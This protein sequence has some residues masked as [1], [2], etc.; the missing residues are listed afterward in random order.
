MTCKW[1]DDSQSLIMGYFDEIQNSPSEIYY[2]ALSFCPPSSWLCEHYSS[3]LPLVKIVKGFQ[4]TWGVCSRTVSFHDSPHILAHWKDIVAVGFSCQIIILDAVTGIQMSV[5]HEHTHLVWALTFSLDGTSLVSGSYDKTIK[6]WDIQTGGVIKTFQATDYPESVSISVD[7][8]TI[9]CLYVGGRIG[10]WDTNPGGICVSTNYDQAHSAIFSFTNPRL[11]LIASTSGAVLQWNIDGPEPVHGD[12][13]RSQCQRAAFSFDRTCC[14]LPQGIAATVLSSESGAVIARLQIP[15]SH[16]SCLKCWCISPNG[17]YVACGAD[18]TI[19]VWDIT[20]SDPHLINTFIG[21]TDR[22]TCVSFSSSLISS[23][24]DKSIKFWQI[25]PIPTEPV[26]TNRKPSNTSSP[27]ITISL[28]AKDNV[29]ILVDE[30]GVVRTWDLS[31]GLCKASFSTKATPNSV[32]DVQ[33]I[34]DRTI[35]VWSTT[36]KMHIWDTKRRKHHQTTDLVSGF[37]NRMLRISGDGSKVFV[38]DCEY[39]RALSTQNGE[40]MGKVRL[41][42]RL[43]DNPLTLDGSRV[44]VHFEDS[45]TQGWDFGIL[46]STPVPLSD[47]PP[48]P[49]SLSLDFINGVRTCGAGPS[50]VKDTVTGKDVYQLTGRFAKPTITQWDGRYLVAGYGTGETLILDFDCMIPK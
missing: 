22:I 9:A 36:K 28:Q 39:L 16:Q 49:H 5:L 24:M 40:I 21:H 50:R 2:H 12:G 10:L 4:T 45:Q 18:V 47:I 30:A 48:D 31:T 1:A 46:G 42:G 13:I 41:E 6:L 11:L 38:L 20:G 19:F 3:E 14:I 26:A 8:A 25:G 37:L 27:P 23:S 43:S 17:K 35:F 33:L 15:A 29:A 44:W 32:R 7:N 34:G